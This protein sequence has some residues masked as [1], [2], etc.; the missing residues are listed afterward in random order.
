MSDPY[1]T[2]NW[3][4]QR[5][6]AVANGHMSAYLKELDAELAETPPGE[7]RDDLELATA[8][9]RMSIKATAGF[10]RVEQAKHIIKILKMRR[11]VLPSKAALRGITSALFAGA[12]F[13]KLCDRSKEVAT[14]A[15]L[16]TDPTMLPVPKDP[17]R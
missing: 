14:F 6:L 12:H 13:A 7:T 2:T 5:A 3:K 11:I 17:V 16:A 8:G 1:H 4:R 10:R 9:L 15:E